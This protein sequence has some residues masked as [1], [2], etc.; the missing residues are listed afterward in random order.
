MTNATGTR[1]RRSWDTVIVNQTY[2]NRG[3]PMDAKQAGALAVDL[4]A[5]AL[6]RLADR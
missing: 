3:L 2:E 4:Y 1:V 6:E 5:E